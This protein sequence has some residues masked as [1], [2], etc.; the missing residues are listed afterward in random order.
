MRDQRALDL[1]GAEAVAGDVEHVIDAAG[2]PVIAVLVAAA[3]VAGEIVALVLGEI[4]VD[5]ALMVAIDGAHLARPAV[6]DGEHALGLGL[7]LQLALG[8]QHDRLDAGIGLVAEPGLVGI[9]PGSGVIR[10]PPVSVCHQVST[11]SQ[12]SLPTCLW[13]HSQASGLIGSPTEPSS[14]S[15]LRE[16]AFTKSSPAPIS[17][18]MA[19]GAV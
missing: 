4:G 18:R 3:A 10:M 9:A 11:I 17:A 16:D 5:E 6:L 15:D 7:L 1:G 19:V 14:R 12:R 13:Y 2:D 8:R